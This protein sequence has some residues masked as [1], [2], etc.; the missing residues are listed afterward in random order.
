MAIF[1]PHWLYW[2]KQNLLHFFIN[3]ERKCKL[4]P[5]A[6]AS[7]DKYL[8]EPL[9]TGCA[10]CNQEQETTVALESPLP[11]H[12]GVRERRHS[13]VLAAC[14]NRTAS[15]CVVTERDVVGLLRKMGV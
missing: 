6:K 10:L 1:Y 2:Y 14:L 13:S 12:R 7:T 5:T 11:D 4:R 8:V 3:A 9:A 15:V